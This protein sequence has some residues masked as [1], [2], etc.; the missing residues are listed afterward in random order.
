[1]PE[2]D[3]QELDVHARDRASAR[4][5]QATTRDRTPGFIALAALAGFFGILGAL[6]TL[7]TQIGSYYFGS[8]KGSKDKT[9][10]MAKLVGGR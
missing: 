2:L 5:R 7:V 9:E 4:Q 3:L 10:A 8:S 1:M 6:V